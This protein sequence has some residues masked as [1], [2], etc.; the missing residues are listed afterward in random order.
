MTTIRRITCLAAGAALAASAFAAY[1]LDDN[2]AKQVIDK[3]LGSQ[4]SEDGPGSA[5]QHVIADVDGDGKPDI[6][7][8]WAI[9]GPTYALPKLTIFI[10]QGKNYRTVTADVFGQTQSLTVKGSTILIDT[11]ALGP[12]DARCCPTVKKRL[13]YRWAGGKLTELK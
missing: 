2:G 6:V 10:D 1:A 11:L 4:K 12:K 3:F 5:G 13:T 9:M 7:L 8:L